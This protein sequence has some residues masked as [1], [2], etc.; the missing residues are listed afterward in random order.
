MTGGVIVEALKL[1]KPMTAWKLL[2]EVAWKPGCK[3]IVFPASKVTLVPVATVTAPL[4]VM[5]LL[6][7]ATGELPEVT[8][9]VSGSVWA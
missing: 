6:A 1:A 7:W 8:V 2:P 4:V 5:V 9:K 3:V